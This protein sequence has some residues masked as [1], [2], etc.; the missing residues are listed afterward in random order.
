MKA[1]TTPQDDKEIWSSRKYKVC[2]CC[3]LM[4]ENVEDASRMLVSHLNSDV[5]NLR[6]PD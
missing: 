1:G 3:P 6:Q 2:Q 5:H 4:A